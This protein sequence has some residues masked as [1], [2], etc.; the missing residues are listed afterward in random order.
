MLPS[1]CKRAIFLLYFNYIA[2][3]L[4]NFILLVNNKFHKNPEVSL[5][6]NTRKDGQK[7]EWTYVQRGGGQHEEDNGCF[8]RI[9]EKR[10]L[11]FYTKHTHT[12][13]QGNYPPPYSLISLT[14]D[15]ENCELLLASLG[16]YS[17]QSIGFCSIFP[18]S[19]FESDTLYSLLE[20]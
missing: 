3:S 13:A 5:R 14:S 20:L 18:Q 11:E 7:F 17:C 1:L 10:L 16:K 2:V 8:S 4:Q 9:C 15:A 19:P 12:D 6:R